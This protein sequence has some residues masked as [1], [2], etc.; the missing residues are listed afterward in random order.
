MTND[1]RAAQEAA[2][3]VV[4][5][6]A[7]QAEA[8]EAVESTEGQE[9]DQPAEDTTQESEEQASETRKRRERRKALS[10]RLERE[11]KEAVAEAEEAKA[12]LAKIEEAT[13]T[14]R[15]PKE[16]DFD[17]YDQY[18]IAVGAY[19]ART[20]LNEDAKGEITERATRADTR[21]KEVDAQRE[22]EAAQ[23]WADQRTE[24]QS[25]YADFDSVVGA[26]PITRDTADLILSSD[27]G[28]DVAYYLGSNPPLA[29]AIARMNPVEAAREF[30]R[31][32]AK[33]SAP[34]PRTK[35]NAPEPV[36]T[37]RPKASATTDPTKMPVDE[38]RKWR[39]SG[40]SF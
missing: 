23:A 20:A 31:I 2:E 8:P 34:K 15:P 16:S 9:E 17:T 3:E 21:L 25:R 27:V 11:R 4:H 39:A 12:R 29:H 19:Q 40:G 1:E 22:Y 28:A 36:G 14:A 37:V 6:E 24:A 18:M 5:S 38:Y 30:G 13:K 10:E 35:S 32:E 7:E 26:V 33:I